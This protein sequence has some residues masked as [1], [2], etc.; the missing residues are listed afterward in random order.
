MAFD[1]KNLELQAG[2]G[3]ELYKWSY[4]TTDAGGTVDGVGYFN[5]AADLLKVGD[6]IQV[7]SSDIIGI[8]FVN[9]VSE[10]GV[11]DVTNL[12]ASSD[13]D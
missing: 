3:N 13:T 10:D 4:V 2:A 8:V 7:K 9:A 11:V 6:A 12:T 1:K 5:K